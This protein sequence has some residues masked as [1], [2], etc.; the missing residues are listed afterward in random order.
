[1]P[2]RIAFLTTHPIQYYAPLYAYLHKA[3]DIEVTGLYLTDLSLR[4]QTDPGFGQKVVWDVDLLSG[5]DP[6]FV[7]DAAFTRERRG[8]FS[9]TSPEIWGLVRRARYDALVIHGHNFMAN[10]IALFAARSVGT[11]VFYRADTHLGKERSG[12]RRCA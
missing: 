6:V 10:Q 11:P 12:F 7:G 3:R 1:M 8:F 2:L 4:G 9:L 5:Y